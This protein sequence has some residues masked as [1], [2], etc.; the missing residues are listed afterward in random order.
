MGRCDDCHLR[1]NLCCFIGV[2]QTPWGAAFAPAT[3]KDDGLTS[4]QLNPIEN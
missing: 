3:I 1:H 4:F 2:R